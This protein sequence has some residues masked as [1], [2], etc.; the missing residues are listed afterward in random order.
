MQPGTAKNIMMWCC[1]LLLSA[2]MQFRMSDNKQRKRFEN[3]GLEA[4]L[5]YIDSKNRSIHYTLSGKDSL[6]PLIMFVHGSPGSS[7]N[8]LYYAQDSVML[9]HYQI[10]LVDRPGFGYSDFGNSVPSIEEQALILSEVLSHFKAPKKILAGHSLGG[11]I[12]C[13]MAMDTSLQ[14]DALLVIAGSVD[15]ELEPKEPWRKPL[16]SK[17]LKWMLPR[18]FRVSNQEI[19]PAKEE[20]KRMQA[21]WKNIKVPITV[22]QGE[23]DKLVPHGNADYIKKM[24]VNSAE[25]KLLK[26]KDK[27]H[28]IPFT[29]EDLVVEA[30][31]DFL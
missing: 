16:D 8:F 21:G 25:V 19:L 18:S 20:L 12:I 26:F 11:P 14:L 27:N 24:A 31:I 1:C 23:K 13:R 4:D 9:S 7:S 22:L 2:C 28:F 3:K 29:D 10:L 5:G 15:P 17:L 6:K 30:A